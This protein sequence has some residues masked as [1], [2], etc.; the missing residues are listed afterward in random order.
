MEIIPPRSRA[1]TRSPQ[2]GWRTAECNFRTT[3]WVCTRLTP[4]PGYRWPRSR[5]YHTQ[6]RSG[7]TIFTNAKKDEPRAIDWLV[8][9]RLTLSTT[10]WTDTRAPEFYWRGIFSKSLAWTR[11]VALRAR[12]NNVRRSHRKYSYFF[13]RQAGPKASGRLIE[14][15]RTIFCRGGKLA[16]R[17]RSSRP[18]LPTGDR[19]A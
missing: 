19:I 5:D 9:S 10:E 1:N 12:I 16:T 15:G 17:A 14:A 7:A 3:T 18:W 8:I 13:T 4:T 11:K 6:S 2:P